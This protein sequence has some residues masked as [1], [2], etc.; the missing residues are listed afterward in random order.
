MNGFKFQI[1]GE[2]KIKI[3]YWTD[4]V[5]LDGII[6]ESNDCDEIQVWY[7]KKVD[8]RIAEK[9]GEIISIIEGDEYSFGDRT[10]SKSINLEQSEDSIFAGFSKTMRYEVRRSAERD[11][12]SISF[13]IPQKYD[14]KVSEYVDFYNAFAK[15]K[16]R[17]ELYVDK[18]IAL[19]DSGAFCIATAK[20]ENG[21]VLVK[22]AYIMCDEM[23][24]IS[25]F[26]SS[27]LFRSNK[28]IS[29]KIGRANGYIQ[30]AV[31]KYFKEKGYKRYD[32]GG[33]Y[34]G[35]KD[36]QRMRISEYKD[37]F[38]G[39]LDQYETGFSISFDQVKNVEKNLAEIRND[40]C[41]RKIIIY[42]YSTWGKYIEKR[43]K[44]IYSAENILIID[45]KLCMTESGIGDES[46]LDECTPIDDYYIIFSTL[47]ENYNKICLGNRVASFY[48]K[49]LTCCLREQGV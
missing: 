41:K 48:D 29:Q 3:V 23:K 9:Y 12:I 18:V 47:K 36:I 5:D 25:L 6:S 40:I 14:D 21:E 32:M 24:V 49:G 11:N 20:D 42:G 22:N 2:R 16:G 30:F 8:R 38:G 4:Y 13:D 31:M 39:E 7:P 17:A 35:D 46:I 10:F 33:Y 44:E 34:N 19:V 28:E 1:E 26:T 43:V 15:D 45:N 37:K 27:S